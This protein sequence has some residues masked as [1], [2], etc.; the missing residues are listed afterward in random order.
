[1][2][3]TILGTGETSSVG[4]ELL[5]VYTPKRETEESDGDK[6]MVKIKME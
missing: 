1:V 3:G 6:F 2:T 5:L 4:L